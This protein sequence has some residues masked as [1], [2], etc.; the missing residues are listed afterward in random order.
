MTQVPP[1]IVG[2]IL[3]TPFNFPPAEHVEAFMIQQENSAGTVAVWRT[4]RTDIDR[5]R[6]AVDRVRAAVAGPFGQLFGFDHPH[7][8]RPARVG[9]GIENV[10][11]RRAEPRNDQ[12]AAFDMRMRSIRTQRRATRIPSEVMQLIADR[13]DFGP[14]HHLR[15]GLRCR[16]EVDHT[17]RIML[18]ILPG[19][20]EAHYVPELLARSVH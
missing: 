9:F 12:V 1:D 11:A 3:R 20:V 2:Q 4:E 19:G 16:I 13:S 18:A 14:T 15:V 7:Y 8:T 6:P 5:V 10:N 17:E